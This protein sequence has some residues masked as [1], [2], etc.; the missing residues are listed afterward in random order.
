MMQSPKVLFFADR[1]YDACPGRAQAELLNELSPVLYIE[2][3]YETLIQA[4][5][6][7]PHSILAL[8]AIQGTP[9]NTHWPDGLESAVKA[10]LKRKNHV[11]LFHGGS[12]A[13]WPWPWWREAMKV[14]WVRKDDPDGEEASWHPTTA[15]EVCLTQQGRASVS[16]LGSFQ[17]PEDELYLGMA[18]KEGVEVWAE[19]EY[20]GR[21]W[22]Q[23]YHHALPWGGTA[24]GWLPGHDAQVMREALRAPFLSVMTAWLS[25]LDGTI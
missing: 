22:P 4:L 11:W 24:F 20:E 3:D 7:H 23:I 19:T 12:A 18:L 13:F 21:F 25:R 2:E 16:G 17:V 1:H 5:E 10:H 8:N 15:Y 6:L 9:G 14:R